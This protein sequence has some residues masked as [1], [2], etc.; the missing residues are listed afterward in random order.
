MSFSCCIGSTLL[1]DEGDD[2]L[3]Q[4]H[5]DLL[6]FAHFFAVAVTGNTGK[7]RAE[8][9]VVLVV[10]TVRHALAHGQGYRDMAPT[11]DLFEELALAGR[12]RHG[13][14]PV[15]RW[16]VSNAVVSFD[17]ANN[18]KPEKGKST[19]RIDPAVAAFMAVAALKLETEDALDIATM[20]G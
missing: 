8:F 20:I 3:L 12:L 1:I 10:A 13:G 16:A 11:L 9:A 6:Q 7:H 2:H 19:G 15:L 14:H 5:A 17:P 4:I 18:R